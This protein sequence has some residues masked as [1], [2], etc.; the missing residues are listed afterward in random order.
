MVE[1]L[2][3]EERTTAACTS[4][5]YWFAVSFYTEENDEDA[6]PSDQDASRMAMRE[7]RRHLVG[8]CHDEAVAL[9]RLRQTCHFRK[10]RYL[11]L[12]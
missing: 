3:H 9:G 7:A 12:L 8:S 5:A 6:K 4:Y 10:V 1:E 2:T 11:Y